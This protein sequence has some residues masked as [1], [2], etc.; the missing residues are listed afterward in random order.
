MLLQEV[1][2]PE[3]LVTGKDAGDVTVQKVS[4]RVM[5]AEADGSPDDLFAGARQRHVVA[6]VGERPR[7]LGRQG[8]GTVLA[9]PDA[10]EDGD[11]GPGVPLRTDELD[12]DRCVGG[13]H[14]C[15]R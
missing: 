6:R 14:A 4:G 15:P 2:D 3:P 11:S 10:G 12:R 7:Q 9:W 13:G 8:F 5:P 1:A